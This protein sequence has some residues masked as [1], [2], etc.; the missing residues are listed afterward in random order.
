MLAAGTLFA[1]ARFRFLIEL[2][3]LVEV[4]DSGHG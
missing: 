2:A 4:I 3:E 1:A